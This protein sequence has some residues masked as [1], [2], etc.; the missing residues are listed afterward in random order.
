MPAHSSKKKSGGISAAAVQAKTGKTWSQWFVL[1]DRD[2]GRTLNHQDLVALL[3]RKYGVG[4]WWQQMVT[5]EYERARGL[6]EKHQTATGYSVSRSKTMNVAIKKL[7][8]AWHQS[9]LR[10][11][12]LAE[13]KLSLRTATTNKSLR[14]I[15]KDGKTQ[16]NVYF[17]AK[18]AGK[19]QVV[20]EHNKLASAAAVKRMQNYWSRKL[21]KLQEFVGA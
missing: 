14:M 18:N 16:V 4:P 8:A 20:I 5:V 21:D 19:S 7:Y 6:R 13:K 15:W 10:D 9:R 3:R 1:L 11:L 2:G 12:W 17:Y